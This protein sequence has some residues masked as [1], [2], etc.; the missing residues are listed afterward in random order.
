[1]IILIDFIIVIAN[2][3]IVSTVRT[4]ASVVSKLRL[5]EVQTQPAVFKAGSS[6]LLL[7][8][9]VLYFYISIFSF[10]REK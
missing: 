8:L 2:V 10:E 1:M 9:L 4:A 3:T 7:P 5:G 6:L